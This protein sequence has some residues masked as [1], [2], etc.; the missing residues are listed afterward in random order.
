MKNPFFMYADWHNA[1]TDKAVKEGLVK[2]TVRSAGL[3]A[4][5]GLIATGL[6]VTIIAAIGG[7]VTLVNKNKNK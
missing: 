2:G 4:L 6:Y 1:Q 3:G 7:V 5:D